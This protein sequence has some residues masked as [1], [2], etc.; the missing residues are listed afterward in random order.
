VLGMLGGGAQD[1]L[2]NFF[3]LVE[4]AGVCHTEHG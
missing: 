1:L 2:S 4:E 3:A